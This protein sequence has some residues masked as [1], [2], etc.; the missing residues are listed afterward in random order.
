MT[1]ALSPSEP[2]GQPE[3]KRKFRLPRWIDKVFLAIGLGLV[4]YVVSRYPMAELGDAIGQLGA[5]VLLSPLA[6]MGWMVANTFALHRLLDR[7]IGWWQLLE[8]RLVGDGYNALL[9]LAGMGGEP[10]RMK[11][12]S[13]HVPA[14]HALTAMIRDRMIENAVGLLFTAAGVAIGLGRY[15]IDT[16]VQASMVVY[17][18]IGIG[19]GIASVLLMVT[20]LPGRAAA[21]LAKRFGVASQGAVRLPP[22]RFAGAVFW[23]LCARVAGVCEVAALM[24]LLGFGVHPID[25]VFMYSMLQAAGFIGFAVPAGVGVFEGATAY[26]FDVLALP[27]PSG[28]AFALARRGRMLAIGLLGVG[29]HLASLRRRQ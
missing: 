14:D 29:L 24:W 12:I 5:G 8:I 16:G 19:G 25:D 23:Y 13:A 27:G 1:A 9:P 10:Y 7:R 22:A 15:A 21:W 11:H 20:S 3:R 28:V 6:A 4:V 17:I 18:A 26:L 2:A